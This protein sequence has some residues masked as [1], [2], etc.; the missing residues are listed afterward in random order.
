MMLVLLV[1]VVYAVHGIWTT[2]GKWG[3]EKQQERETLRVQF[4]YYGFGITKVHLTYLRV[5]NIIA[6]IISF[7]EFS[8]W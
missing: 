1:D 4:N 2:R 6:T 8:R 7:I 5:H 3:K